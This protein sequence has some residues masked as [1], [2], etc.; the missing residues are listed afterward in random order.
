MWCLNNYLIYVLHTNRIFYDTSFAQCACY[1]CV[2]VW[3]YSSI[4]QRLLCIALHASA[5][6]KSVWWAN[7]SKAIMFMS[8]KPENSML[9]IHDEGVQLEIIGMT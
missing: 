1:L 5:E 3:D 7:K 8:T 9:F 6:W 2:C 4:N